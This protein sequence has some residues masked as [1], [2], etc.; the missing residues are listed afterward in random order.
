MGDGLSGFSSPVIW[1]IVFVFFIARGCIKTGLGERLA[2]QCIQRL[3]KNPIGLGYG[4]I[5]TETVLG[6][7]IPSNTA[8]AG[9]IIYPILKSINEGLG[10]HP[11]PQESARK[12]GRFLVQIA[13]HGNIISSSLFLTGM[14]CNPLIQIIAAKQGV[15]ITWWGWFYG[16]LAPGLVCILLIPLVLYLLDPPQQKQFPEAVNIA[17]QKLAQKGKMTRGEWS[18][19]GIFLMMVALW[20]GGDWIGVHVTSTALF[21]VIALLV[22]KIMDWEEMLKEKEAWNL[23]VWLAILVSFSSGLEKTGVISWFS[24]EITLL[25]H[26]LPWVQSLGLVCLIYFYTH[27][28]FASTV[29]HTTALYAAFLGVAIQSGAPAVVSALLL[30]YTSSCFCCLTHYGSVAAAILYESGYVPITN[31]FRN[32]LILSLVYLAIWGGI[33]PLWWAFIKLW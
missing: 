13:F 30:A 26:G 19:S 18:M 32:G 22:C 16:A 33:G 3:G 10:S 7:L 14:V 20:I 17:R 31:W 28:F 1:M 2:Y 9:G 8:R 4:L 25:L 23:F 29:A 21:G 27:Y 5:L 12:I 15:N 24:E 6:A 11:H